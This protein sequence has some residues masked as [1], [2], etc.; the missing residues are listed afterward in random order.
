MII[1]EFSTW[2]CGNNLYSV[3][4]IEVEE[5]PKTYIGR[6]CRISKSDIDMLDAGY[7]HRM[8]RLINDPAHY[9]D[10]MV[11]LQERRVVRAETDLKLAKTNL[12]TWRNYRRNIKED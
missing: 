7:G 8:Y 3:K 12:E 11:E 6:G 4:E 10:K 2:F 1:Y 9:I 5:K